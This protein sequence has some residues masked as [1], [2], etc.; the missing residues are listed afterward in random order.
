MKTLFVLGRESHVFFPKLNAA[1]RKGI[2]VAQSWLASI[3]YQMIWEQSIRGQSR[4]A[5]AASSCQVRHRTQDCQAA[6]LQRES[7]ECDGGRT[8]WTMQ[9]SGRQVNAHTHTRARA[10]MQTHSQTTGSSIICNPVLLLVLGTAANPE[11]DFAVSVFTSAE[12]AR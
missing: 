3:R 12:A 1:A 4:S 7:P 5:S 2:P 6:S 11:L 10:R 9:S 8:R